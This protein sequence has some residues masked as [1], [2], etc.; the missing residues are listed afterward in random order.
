M[1][2]CYKSFGF[3][4]KKHSKRS[5]KKI[6]NTILQMYKIGKKMGFI[7][8]H[9]SWSRGLTKEIDVRLK[10][11]AED[12]KGRTPWNKGLTKEKDPRVMQYAIKIQIYKRKNPTKFTKEQRKR[13]SNR[14]KK[15]YREHPE[16]HPNCR[17]RKDN[18]ISQ[19][20]RQ[21]YNIVKGLF[22]K[23][24]ILMEFPIKVNKNLKFL[25]IAIPSL[26]IDIEYDGSYWHKDKE[27]D[28]KRDTALKRIGWRVIRFNKPKLDKLNEPQYKRQLYEQ[29]TS[30]KNS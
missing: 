29:I 3:K 10:K 28:K 17:M 21:L 18:Y 15:L 13:I 23:Y 8:G 2:E 12:A 11:K 5:R 30:T 7:K 25:D 4:N 16:K 26:K 20:Q 22:P 24:K 14:F 27:K 6:R 19:W 9:I 1:G